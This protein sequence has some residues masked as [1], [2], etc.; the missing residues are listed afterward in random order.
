MKSY[1]QHSGI[2]IYHGDCRE[3]LPQLG[4]TEVIITDPPYPD[5]HVKLYGYDPTLIEALRTIAC[6]QL[7]FWSAKAD[8]PLDF[9]AVHIWDKRTGCGS[10]YER[11]VERS[12]GANWKVFRNYAILNTTAARFQRDEFTGHPS[13]KPRQ[14]IKRLIGY[15]G[16]QTQS[17]TDPFCGSGTILLAAKE[18]GKSAIGIEIEEKY[19]EIAAKRLS[20][21]VFDFSE[22]T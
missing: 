5:Y 1:Y 19:C 14:L 18:L 12:G 11:I 15:I 16:T 22:R 4:R 6:R 3:V 20:Q 21:E 17:I 13:Q 10:E 8:F 9:T 7:I 2:T